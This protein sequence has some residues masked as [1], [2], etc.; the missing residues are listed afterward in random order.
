MARIVNPYNLDVEDDDALFA[1]ALSQGLIWIEDDDDD[2]KDV[3]ES[4]LKS[5][6]EYL[7]SSHQTKARVLQGHRKRVNALEVQ[8]D[9]I[10]SA[11][12]DRTI[13][14]WNWNTG[15]LVQTLRGH[16][17]GVKSLAISGDFVISASDDKTVRIWNWVTGT[18][19]RTLGGYS[20]EVSRLVIDGD[21]VA[22]VSHNE[23]WMWNWLT[24]EL[25]KKLTEAHSGIVSSIIVDGDLILSASRDGAVVHNWRSGKMLHTFG[26]E[27]GAAINGDRIGLDRDFFVCLGFDDIYVWRWKTGVS[28]SMFDL[29]SVENRDITT[30]AFIIYANICLF[31]HQ[32]GKWLFYPID[33]AYDKVALIQGHRNIIVTDHSGWMCVIHPNPSLTRVMQLERN[34]TQ[35]IEQSYSTG[36]V[37]LT[38]RNFLNEHGEEWVNFS[39]VSQ[40]LHQQFA[41]LKPQQLGHP[42][43][44]YSS[45][46]KFFADF[47]YDFELRRDA[48]KQGLYW[49]RLQTSS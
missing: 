37:L 23:I 11:S 2:D 45:L 25:V 48:K 19:V 18:H 1:G 41:K 17:R 28:L 8:G 6:I 39:R 29:L 16:K 21:T 3:F 24:G 47:P 49:I 31:S 4:Y 30:R 43:K 32:I 44:N 40:H 34:S 22:S 36:E 13:C 27:I 46:V 15:D 12:E 33:Y 7:D 14:V 26:M 9:N 35:H 5:K 42:S 10:F 20:H 38:A